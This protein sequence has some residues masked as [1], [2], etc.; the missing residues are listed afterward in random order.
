MRCGTFLRFEKTRESL[1]GVE[2]EVLLGNQSFQSKKVLDPGDLDRR[3]SYQPFPRDE[4]KLR[5]RKVVEPALKVLRVDA[6][7]QRGP[8]CVYDLT[9]D[10]EKGLDW[11]S[12]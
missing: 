7:S 3:I 4:E 6:N 8:S 11:D 2:V 10:I 1:R 9:N 12:I 5:Q